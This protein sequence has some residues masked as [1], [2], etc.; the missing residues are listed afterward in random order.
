MKNKIP[1]YGI[2]EWDD[3]FA[4][5]GIN[6]VENITDEFDSQLEKHVASGFNNIV[7]ALGRATLSYWSEF[8]EIHQ[9]ASTPKTHIL[10]HLAMKE[11]CPLR[12]AIDWGRKGNIPIWG[13]LCMNRFYMPGQEFRSTFAENHPEYC[14]IMHDGKKDYTRLSYAI[15]EVRKERCDI[16]LEAQRIGVDALVLDFCRQPP[17]TGYHEDEL[18]D[19]T[20]KTG[21]DPRRLQGHNHEIFTEWFSSRAQC[22]T[23]F[24]RELRTSVAEQEQKYNRKC[25]I[26]IRIPA[27]SNWLLLAAGIDLNSW[28]KENLFDIVMLSPLL[29]SANDMTHH[30]EHHVNT[31]HLNSKKIIGGIGSL[32]VIPQQITNINQPHGS[33]E[34]Q[35]IWNMAYRQLNAGVDG[36]SVYQ[37]DTICNVAWLKSIIPHLGTIGIC[38]EKRLEWPRLRLNSLLTGCDWHSNYDYG[39]NGT[40]TRFVL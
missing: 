10:G 23:T 40:G 11:F 34:E 13:R 29:W 37:T 7:W 25:P 28:Y 31:A 4:G 38:A 14:Q 12:R 39:L 22:V 30:F 17:M 15:P 21:K 6:Q 32:N 3:Y 27:S 24:M 35:P 9:P 16:L 2:C 26:V 1:L 36:M 5:K 20:E 19:Y 33:F 8:N 18:K